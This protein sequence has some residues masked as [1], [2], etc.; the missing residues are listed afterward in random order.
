MRP[1]EKNKPPHPY[2]RGGT[3]YLKAQSACCF[4]FCIGAH[5]TC[6]LPPDKPTDPPAD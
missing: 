1:R 3:A 6:I 2:G 5:T 4:T